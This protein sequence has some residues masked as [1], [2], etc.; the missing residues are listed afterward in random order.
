MTLSVIWTGYELSNLITFIF[1]EEIS[2][3]DNRYQP[4][5]PHWPLL[6]YFLKPTFFFNLDIK[7]LHV[8][9]RNFATDHDFHLPR[10][11][12]W[13]RREGGVSEFMILNPTTIFPRL[14]SAEIVHVLSP[15][16]FCDGDAG[17][18]QNEIRKWIYK[19][20]ETAFE[21]YKWLSRT[22]LESKALTFCPLAN[23]S[24]L[25]PITELLDWLYHITKDKGCSSRNCLRISNAPMNQQELPKREMGV[26]WQGERTDCEIPRLPAR[27]VVLQS[28]YS[29][30]FM[31]NDTLVVWWKKWME[32]LIRKNSSAPWADSRNGMGAGHKPSWR[33]P[34]LRFFR[35]WNCC[36]LSG[37]LHDHDHGK[38]DLN[39][40]TW[41]SNLKSSYQS[42]KT[43]NQGE[44]TTTRKGTIQC[45]IR[46]GLVREPDGCTSDERWG[47][48]NFE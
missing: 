39:E 11:G 45:I 12:F 38:G 23:L 28:V 25:L 1:T 6:I 8:V 33:V 26:V 47:C 21:S 10:S 46:K 9:K 42:A 36:A 34:H 7:M 4:T 18:T 35:W 14:V 5:V 15:N 44:R 30:F 17:T 27:V 2:C 29:R 40:A 20:C 16:W 43:S 13:R 48:S 41:V 24:L 32:I 22:S 3:N 37:N 31:R 19:S